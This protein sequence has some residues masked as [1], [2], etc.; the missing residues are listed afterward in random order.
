MIESNT[1]SHA[2]TTEDLTAEDRRLV[3]R[4]ERALSHGLDLK[5]WWDQADSS[6]RYDTRFELSQSHNSAGSSFGFFGEAL[7]DH[8]TMAVMGNVQEMFYDRPKTPRAV[9]AHPDLRVDDRLTVE[10][11]P[12]WLNDQVREYVLH[13]FMR[14]STFRQPE[15]YPDLEER[16]PPPD[17]LRP[18]SWRPERK[19]NKAGFGFR[20]LLYKRRD[21]GE[22]G[23]FS[24][25]EEHT[26]VDMRELGDRYDWIVLKVQIYD[27][28]FVMAPLGT[29][30]PHLVAPISEASYLVV[31]REFI[32]NSTQPGAG[33]L[34]R[35][36]I[37]YAFVKNDEEGVLGY[38]PGHFDAAFQVINFH[39]RENGE[40]RSRMAFVANRPKKIA[41]VSLDPVSWSMRMAD[42]MSMGATSALMAPVRNAW[43]RMPRPGGVDV[44]S[45]Y[46]SMANM[47]SGGLAERELSIS[48]DQLERNFLLQHFT[49]HYNTIT[50]SVFTWRQIP[51]WLD[52]PALP[53]WVVKGK[54]T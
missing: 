8:E 48:R 34:G 21:T 49:Q 3:D 32:L 6:E 25:D 43:E 29:E 9:T 17:Y 19:E 37:G 35:F 23:R 13:Y 30:A 31:S 10:T 28:K 2:A 38:G 1:A 27:F 40:I 52:R 54:S 18:L 14:T 45:A 11:Y 53:D 16:E 47:V 15:A 46:I 41:N 24:E 26:I 12:H 44:V 20:Q 36:G 7:V 5:R 42:M 33:E 22:V 4:V 39:V 51:D 50:S